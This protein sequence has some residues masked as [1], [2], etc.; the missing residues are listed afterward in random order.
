MK[1]IMHAF[2]LLLLLVACGSSKRIIEVPVIKEVNVEKIVYD[3]IYIHDSVSVPFVY[4][5]DDS[6]PPELPIQ[7]VYKTIYKYK[8]RV[9]DSTRVDTIYKTKD[10]PYEVE[11]KLSWLQKTQIKGFNAIVAIALL[12]FGISYR[13]KIFGFIIKYLVR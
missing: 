1:N 10:V 4:C 2:V 12:Y 8:D 13:K 3:S 6:V 9:I 5:P 7:Y 11:K